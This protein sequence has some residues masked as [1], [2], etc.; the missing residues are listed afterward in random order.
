[1]KLLVE[2][3][4]DRVLGVHMLGDDAPEIVQCLAVAE[5]GLPAGAI[6]AALATLGTRIYGRK[7]NTRSIEGALQALSSA[8]QG[9][10]ATN[11]IPQQLSGWF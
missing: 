9:A 7:P 6:C 11:T 2:P 1:M 4:S 10:D 5:G 3:K 8:L